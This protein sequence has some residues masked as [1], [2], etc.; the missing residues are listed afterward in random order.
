MK[1][2][3]L[4][5]ILAIPVVLFSLFVLYILFFGYRI[6]RPRPEPEPALSSNNVVNDVV[7]D[8]AVDSMAAVSSELAYYP[9]DTT[10]M[11]LSAEELARIKSYNYQILKPAKK[12]PDNEQAQRALVQLTEAKLTDFIINENVNIKIG[13]CYEN[14]NTDGN[15]NCV[16]CMVFIYDRKLKDESVSE[17]RILI[18]PAYDFY[19]ASENDIWEA[20]NISL[21]IPFDHKLFKQYSK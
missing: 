16:S 17:A 20:K 3:K 10:G 6:H 2:K 11:V 12:A 15:F 18:K 21:N 14:P 9:F 5:I 1:Y 19:Q 13:K 7:S 4:L 8:E